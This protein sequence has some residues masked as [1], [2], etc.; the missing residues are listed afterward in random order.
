[1]I[2]NGFDDV[3]RNSDL[4]HIG[5]DAAAEIVQHPR[6]HRIGAGR[7]ARSGDPLIEH[8]LRDRIAGEAGSP[9]T[10]NGGSNSRDRLEQP[11]CWR[12]Q[13]HIMR[14]AILGTRSRQ[15]DHVSR[16]VDLGPSETADLLAALAGEDQEL[17]DGSVGAISGVSPHLDKL[18]IAEHALAPLA[19]GL[20]VGGERWI[21]VGQPLP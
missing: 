7:L 9:R 6:Q 19:G 4:R 18:T 17:E 21:G 1:V 12:R 11:Q 15:P 8:A 2:E 5:R 16:E 13:R 20:P 10:E 3:R 14:L